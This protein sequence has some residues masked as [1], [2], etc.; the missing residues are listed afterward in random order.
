MEY[1]TQDDFQKM[2]LL[3]CRKIDEQ[4]EEI[5][6]INVFPVPD[7]DTGNNIAKTLQGIEES[8][9]DRKFEDM[10]KISEAILDG[11]LTA[12]QGN[13]GVIYTGFLAGFFSLLDKN[14]VN[15]EKISE[16]FRE[17]SKR[18]RKSIQKPQE[19]T[20]LDVIDSTAQTFEANIGKEKNI[21]NIFKKAVENAREALLATREKME[22]FRKANVVDAGGLAFL[23]ILESHLEALNP[24]EKRKGG[25]KEENASGQVKRFIQTLSNRYEVVSLV[26]DLKA[27]EETIR[28][29]LKKLGNS[30]D[31]VR[32]ENKMKIHI[33]T[34]YPDEV[35]KIIRGTGQVVD[36]REE[37]M[38]K[39][40]GGENSVRN[41]SVGVVTEDTN[42]L[43]QK[44]IER[45]GIGIIKVGLDW[46]E[47]EN[48]PGKNIYQKMRAAGASGN[49]P[50]PKT[51]QPSPKD[52]LN[53]FEDR[54]EKFREVLCITIN[55]KIS[56]C[57]NSACQARAML[58][59]EK[60]KRV[61]VLDSLQ[62]A[63]G[64]SLL[65]LRAVELIQEQKEIG[66]LVEEIKKIIPSINL[67]GILE[68]PG[69]AEAGGRISSSQA[70][71]IR[72][73]KKIKL[74]PL[75]LMKNGR[76]S[77]GGIVSASGMAE[78]LYKK[79]L[80]KSRR[81]REAGRNLRAVISHADNLPEAEKL[82]KM[83]KN[84]GFEISYINLASPVICAHI[85]PGS[86]LVGWHTIN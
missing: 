43:L 82:K 51:Y 15:A 60:R 79:I 38:A 8:I 64:Q 24:E 52:Y 27:D 86:L 26:S 69:W 42:D 11:A 37:D 83:L 30:L 35:K 78:A 5:N 74:Y 33:H 39:E 84:I 31:I 49:K 20:I 54:L 67:Y 36:L 85:G 28:C 12:A 21:V 40:V 22:I 7:Q 61:Y 23:I 75:M 59:P 44:N 25:G 16:A 9:R 70:N 56:G 68:D 71:W 13:A 77:S 48:F 34:D 55:S 46:P 73:I 10:G 3:S 76:V 47:I 1:L 50:L 41:L 32:I 2:I 19:G 81:D 4:K 53:M 63:S 6:K 45:Y 18:A 58:E 66:E 72:R 14:P 80:K 62:A 17:G 57:Y 65:V 29:R